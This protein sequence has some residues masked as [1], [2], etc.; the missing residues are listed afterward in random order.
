MMSKSLKLNKAIK[1]DNLVHHLHQL[2]MSIE[3]RVEQTGKLT[4]LLV[5]KYFMR[6]SNVSCCSI[7]IYSHSH[8]EHDVIVMSGG[9]AQGAF[10]KLSWGSDTEFLND[11]CYVLEAYSE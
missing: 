6:N 1:L 5:E 11:V 10:L 9:S 3:V 2:G 4:S 8:V 7:S